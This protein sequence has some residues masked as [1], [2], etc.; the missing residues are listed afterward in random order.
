MRTLEAAP[1]R[2]NDQIRII[3]CTV[4]SAAD[5]KVKIDELWQRKADLR[6]EAEQPQDLPVV[7]ADQR[8]N[9]LVIASSPEDFAEIKRLIDQLEAQPLAPIAEIRLITLMTLEQDPHR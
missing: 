4:A 5:L 7:V 3:N 6:G 8:S 2:F 1:D 9:S